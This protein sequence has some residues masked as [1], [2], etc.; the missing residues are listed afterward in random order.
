MEINYIEDK[1]KSLVFEV[2]NVTHGFCNL[3][4]EELAKDKNVSLV[5][6][7]IDHPQTGVPRFKIEGD[8]P[9]KSIKTAIKSLKKE[10]EGLKKEVSSKL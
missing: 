6:Y 7:R 3:L 4:K 1:K 5:T 10:F 2:T 8:D 9:K